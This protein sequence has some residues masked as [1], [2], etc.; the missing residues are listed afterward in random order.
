MV[1]LGGMGSTIGVCLAAGFLTI[2]PEVLRQLPQWIE[3]GGTD[4]LHGLGW[5]PANY[6]V[7]LPPSV[8]DLLQNRMILYSLLLIA[9]MLLRPQGLFSGWGRKGPGK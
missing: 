9:L 2:L 6:I 1:I 7:K 5:L 4:A 8:V 3:K